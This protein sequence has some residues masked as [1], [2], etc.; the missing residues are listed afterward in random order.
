MRSHWEALRA[1]LVRSLETSETTDAFEELRSRSPHFDG[2]PSAAFLAASLSAGGSLGARDPALWALI[3]A[4]RDRR[5]GRLAQTILLV[6]FWPALDAIFRRRFN[7]FPRRQHELSVELVDCF[8]MELQRADVRRVSCLSA[9]LLRN[10]D[11]NLVR[12]RARERALAAKATAVTPNVAVVE[13]PEPVASPFGLGVEQTDTE[14][15]AVLTT[16]LRNAIGTDSVVVAAAVFGGKTCPEIA[17]SLGIS[18]AAARK[19]LC[20]ALARARVAF[21]S[22]RQ[23]QPATSTAFVN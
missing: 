20:R 7:L 10:T 13:P 16:W 9:T 6:C 12:R 22:E 2:V 23:S 18:H 21:L 1:G 8:I 5:V 19:R 15:I 11:R 17:R 4:A 14:T 3:E